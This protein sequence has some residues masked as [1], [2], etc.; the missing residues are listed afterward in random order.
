MQNLGWTVH[1][2][3]KAMEL[4]K[5]V[6]KKSHVPDVGNTGRCEETGMGKRGGFITSAA[7]VTIKILHSIG[8]A[9]VGYGGTHAMYTTYAKKNKKLTVTC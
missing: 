4:N 7:S 3:V 2:R 6:C 8:C 5:F 9:A 1:R